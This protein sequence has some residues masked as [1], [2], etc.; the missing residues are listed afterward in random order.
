[1]LVSF[2][3]SFYS[4]HSS[5]SHPS[6]LP[7]LLYR[8]PGTPNALRSHPA[9]AQYKQAWGHCNEAVRRST[10]KI[11]LDQGLTPLRA[12][13]SE[14]V[15]E[16]QHEADLREAYVKDYDSYRRRFNTLQD[17]QAK[18][19]AAPPSGNGG[20]NP[21][22]AEVEKQLYLIQSKL[23]AAEDR[24][25]RQNTK[26]KEEMIKAKLMRDELL[27][28]A[29]RAIVACQVELFTQT[30]EHLAQLLQALPEEERVASLRSQVRELVAKG[31][32]EA[33]PVEMSQ[34]EK[35]VKAVAH[36]F[37]PR[38]P[39]SPSSSGDGAGLG[40]PS[41][42]SGR[43]Q[44]QQQQQHGPSVVDQYMAA[45]GSGERRDGGRNGS[46]SPPKS[47]N[48]PAMSNSTALGGA[49]GGS[50]TT[51]TRS[52]S[53]GNIFTNFF[54]RQ[55]SGGGE[56]GSKGGASTTTTTTTTAVEEN[57][58]A[59]GGYE[60]M[61][62]SNGAANFDMPLAVATATAVVAAP[63]VVMA[64]ALYD[65]EPEDETELGFVVGDLLEI[66]TKDDSGWWEAR[67][68]GKVGSIPAN[69]VEIVL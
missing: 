63:P 38:T 65:N 61:G 24:Y 34:M 41:S 45:G 55:S 67:L 37:T 33:R 57:M 10:T 39:P 7:S 12:F 9:A 36:N 6:L 23:H 32:P 17:K 30:G 28:N 21:R 22:L 49:G 27:E 18:Y 53:N 1:V 58:D 29:L 35:M 4:D 62:S 59:T 16:I 15:P 69:Y 64:R 51:T 3:G 20:A 25:R 11:W 14:I 46:M 50:T 60:K 13:I 8:P 52:S 42:Q 43:Q 26:I 68:N 31:G 2:F 19:A 54:N 56:E 44:Q 66:L 40:G 48:K 5:T 47:P